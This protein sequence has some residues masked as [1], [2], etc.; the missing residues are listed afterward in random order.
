MTAKE[1][2]SQTR[3]AAYRNAGHP[4]GQA[5]ATLALAASVMHLAQA[6]YEYLDAHHA[7]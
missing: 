6:L 2:Y 3:R 7:G 4:S 1:Q 5:L